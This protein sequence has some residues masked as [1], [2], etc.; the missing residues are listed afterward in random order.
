MGFGVTPV[1]PDGKGGVLFNWTKWQFTSKYAIREF[2]RKNPKYA[3][4]NVGVVGKRGVNNM[5]FLDIDDGSVVERIKADT[6]CDMPFGYTVATRPNSSHRH[7]YFRH[8]A[9][10]FAAFGGRGSKEINVRDLT[11]YTVGKSGLSQHPTIY[12]L[13]GVGNGALVVAAGSVR[14]NGDRYTIFLDGPVPEVPDWLVNWLVKDVKEYK[15]GKNAERISKLKAKA[16]ERAKIKPEERERMRRVSLPEGFDIYE[17]DIPSFLRSRS[18]TFASQGFS[19]EEIKLLLRMQCSR[20][21]VNGTSFVDSEK[22]RELIAKLADHPKL[23]IGDARWFYRKNSDDASD[24][25]GLV[26]RDTSRLTAMALIICTFPPQISSDEVYSRLEEGLRGQFVF[27]RVANKDQQAA[28]R[29][30]KKAGFR[31]LN[32][33]DGKH[34]WELTSEV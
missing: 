22:G 16:E 21:C 20:F 17:E 8:T 11:R 30:M 18:G 23:K 7:H 10:S 4:H 9:H 13:K 33:G 34:K 32:M 31:S 29:A 19:R 27:N 6:G 5:F 2:V 1:A 25:D 28:G 26:F 24:W 12:D 3:H 15:A 14:E